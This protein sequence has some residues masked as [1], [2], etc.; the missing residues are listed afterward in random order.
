MRTGTR[1]C[2]RSAILSARMKSGS[3]G[4]NSDSC[5][6]LGCRA[7]CLPDPRPRFPGHAG[8]PDSLG[9]RGSGDLGFHQAPLRVWGQGNLRDA[10]QAGLGEGSEPSPRAEVGIFS[11]KGGRGGRPP[12]KA[13]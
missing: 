8:D 11:E 10:G 4:K 7:A 9:A 13:E 5:A 1:T 12:C 2:W 6:F 3:A